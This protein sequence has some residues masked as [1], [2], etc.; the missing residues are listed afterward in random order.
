MHM[1]MSR[2]LGMPVFAADQ[3]QLRVLWQGPQGEYCKRLQ[4]QP[5]EPWLSDAHLPACSD[6][7]IREFEFGPP[8]QS[9]NTVLTTD[10]NQNISAPYG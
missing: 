7:I 6:R 5:T 8:Q 2:S 4:L 10:A 9:L 3:L 1:T